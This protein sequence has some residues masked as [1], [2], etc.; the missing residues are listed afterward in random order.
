MWKYAYILASPFCLHDQSENQNMRVMVDRSDR[1]QGQHTG[2]TRPSR[3]PDCRRAER[4]EEERKKPVGIP[5]PNHPSSV[6]CCPDVRHVCD[7]TLDR[8]SAVSCCELIHVA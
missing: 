3:V 5:S 4:A 7:D 2:V 1:A 6:V 8:L